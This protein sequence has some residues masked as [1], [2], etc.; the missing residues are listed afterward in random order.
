MVPLLPSD[1]TLKPNPWPL[2]GSSRETIFWCR[3][4]EVGGGEESA[5]EDGDSCDHCGVGKR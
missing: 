1:T 5:Q 2:L 4:D 3:M